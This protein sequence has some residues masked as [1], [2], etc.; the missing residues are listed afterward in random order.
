LQYLG[1]RPLAQLDELLAGASTEDLESAQLD[2][3]QARNS[4]ASAQRELAETE[5]LAPFTGVVT[6]VDASA[7]E[8]IGTAAFV[9]LA[10][11]ETP[12]VR[13]WVEESDLA[14]VVV[15]NRVNIIFEALPDDVYTGEIVRVEPALVSVD[16]TPAVQSWASVDLTSNS[17]QLLAGM[18]AD[19]VEVV[20]A[21]AKDA[22]LVPLQALR[23]VSPG[24]YAVFVLGPDDELELRSVEVG[25][26]DLVNAEILS[27]LSLGEEVSVG[28]STTAARGS[29]QPPTEGSPPADGMMRMMGG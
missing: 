2:V 19:E 27:G 26:K 9:A 8:A 12:L 18:T 24:Q 13:L 1:Y 7:G 15:G 21:E 6:S 17:I 5:L 28:A 29:A 25:L 16:S 22:L 10:D 14:S 23:E 11:L 3:E 20:A 4:L